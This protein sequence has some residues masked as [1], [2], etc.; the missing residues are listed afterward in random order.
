MTNSTKLDFWWIY[1]FK[2]KI[3]EIH[4]YKIITVLRSLY[5]FSSYLVLVYVRLYIKYPEYAKIRP[6][7]SSPMI[8]SLSINLSLSLQ[9]EPILFNNSLWAKF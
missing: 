7:F 5:G 6:K 2:K 8:K 9:V 3:F 4:I 1:L